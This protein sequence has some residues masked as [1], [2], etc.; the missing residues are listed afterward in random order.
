M[1]IGANDGIWVSTQ[2]YFNDLKAYC[3]ARQAAGYKVVL[4]TI[5]PQSGT[6][7]ASAFNT[8]RAI[9]NA[10]IRSDSSFWDAL[11][12]FA[13]NATMGPDS[14]AAN[15]TYYSDGEHPTDVGY[16]ILAPIASAA[17]KSLL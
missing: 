9:I 2:T 6:P 13:N 3:Q 16:S 5:L 15:T 14:A 12:D 17:I 4:G 1:F 10:S 8:A 7:N 11:S